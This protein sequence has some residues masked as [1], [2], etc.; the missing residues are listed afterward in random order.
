MSNHFKYFSGSLNGLS[1]F[2]CLGAYYFLSNF[3]VLPF[4][5]QVTDKG[6]CC[7]ARGACAK[8]LQ[9]SPMLALL[10][11]FKMQLTNV[12]L[13][14]VLLPGISKKYHVSVVKRYT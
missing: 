8:A 1:S 7:L 12:R 10:L 4:L 2:S 11:H 9:V 6:L 13:L 5:L 14:N 3:H